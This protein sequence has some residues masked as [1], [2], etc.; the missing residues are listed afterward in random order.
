MGGLINLVG[1]FIHTCKA[2]GDWGKKDLYDENTLI[3]K[4]KQCGLVKQNKKLR[5]NL[6]VK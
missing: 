3:S 1:T 4:E 2:M 6:W 5:V